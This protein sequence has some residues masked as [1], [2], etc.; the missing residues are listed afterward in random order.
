[1]REVL[2]RGFSDSVF[3]PRK[4]T[5]PNGAALDEA[6]GSAKARETTR[7]APKSAGKRLEPKQAIK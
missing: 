7:L 6:S 5:L 3:K 4:G 2:S 1:M